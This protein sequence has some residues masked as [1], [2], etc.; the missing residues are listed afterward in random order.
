GLRRDGLLR[1]RARRQQRRP[2]PAE[3]AA[4]AQERT[5]RRL[6][7]RLERGARLP[8]MGGGGQ[9]GQRRHAGARLPRDRGGGRADERRLSQ[10]RAA[11]VEEPAQGVT[12]WRQFVE[13]L[14]GLGLEL[15]LRDPTGTLASSRSGVVG[16]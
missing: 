12:M 14:M 15:L 8:V 3:G 4:R 5:Q 9:A 1:R 11:P 2:V 7:L 13:F 6:P 16:G 10:P